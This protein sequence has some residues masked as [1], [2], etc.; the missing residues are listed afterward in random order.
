MM[1][2]DSVFREPLTFQVIPFDDRKICYTF[3]V[4]PAVLKLLM[5]DITLIFFLSNLFLLVERFGYKASLVTG[6]EEAF[7]G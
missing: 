5:T 1:L 3:V 6:I 2:A 7:I 4:S